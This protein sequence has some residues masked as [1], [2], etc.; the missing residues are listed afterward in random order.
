M[1]AETQ[2]IGFA[3][4]GFDIWTKFRKE[5]PAIWLDYISSHYPWHRDQIVFRCDGPGRIVDLRVGDFSATDINWHEHIVITSLAAGETM[6]V[7]SQFTHILPNGHEI[8]Y[9]FRILRSGRTVEVPVSFSDLR[10]RRYTQSFVLR[11]ERN[12]IS[13]VSVSVGKPSKR[14]WPIWDALKARFRRL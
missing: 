10:G 11:R 12:T 6:T 9:M 1:I 13:D 3:R 7:E 5:P 4:S 14:R 2:A 8:G